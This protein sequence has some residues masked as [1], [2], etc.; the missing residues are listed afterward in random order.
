MG[1][2]GVVGLALYL[3][4]RVEQWQGVRPRLCEAED[5]GEGHLGCPP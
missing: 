4:V 1:F 3:G 2:K 5:N